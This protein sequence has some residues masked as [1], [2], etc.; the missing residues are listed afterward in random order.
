MKVS[1]TSWI[2]GQLRGINQGLLKIFLFSKFWFFEY[3][4]AINFFYLSGDLCDM[5]R[6][7]TCKVLKNSLFKRRLSGCSRFSLYKKRIKVKVSVVE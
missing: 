7:A 5:Q 3:L 6:K 1:V 4:E 2:C